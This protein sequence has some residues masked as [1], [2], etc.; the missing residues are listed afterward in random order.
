M[1]KKTYENKLM[2]YVPVDK[3]ELVEKLREILK[4]EG[5]TLSRFF[6]EYAQRYYEQHKAGNPQLLMVHYVKPEEPQPFRVKC[7]YLSGVLSPN[8]VY[9]RKAGM[10]VKSIRCYSCKH[11]QLRK[12]R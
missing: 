2:L 4:R 11:N 7:P 12:N 6:F 5:K 3:R 1:S 9:C 10:W 8:E